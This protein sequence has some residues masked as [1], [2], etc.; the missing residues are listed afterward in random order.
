VLAV[1]GCAAG[2][3]VWS[4]WFPAGFWGAGGVEAP[5][6]WARVVGRGG[7][8]FFFQNL[9]PGEGWARRAGLTGGEIFFAAEPTGALD[10]ASGK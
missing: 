3:A 5:C 9:I 1:D 10:T 7:F 6:G 2:V 8:L 4:E